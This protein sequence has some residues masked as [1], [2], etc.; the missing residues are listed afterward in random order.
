MA[1]NQS[2]SFATP[3]EVSLMTWE[4]LHKIWYETWVALQKPYQPVELANG[5]N[6]SAL[7]GS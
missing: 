2:V 1:K 3:P 5:S 4:E 6:T 7:R